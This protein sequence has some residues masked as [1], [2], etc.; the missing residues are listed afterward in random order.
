MIQ[1]DQPDNLVVALCQCGCGLPAPI[2]ARTYA[3]WGHVKG[4]PM[5]F[6]RGH[7]SRMG[8]SAKERFWANVVHEGDCWVWR[9]GRD[10]DGYG[11]LKVSG[12][13]VRAH[14]FAYEMYR[15]AAPGPMFV[16]HTC[17]NPPCV[18]PSH[19]FLGTAIDNARDA[20][21]KGRMARLIG[22]ANPRS[23]PRSVVVAVAA[24]PGSQREVA[25]RLGVAQA[26]VSRIRAGK[27]S[28]TRSAACL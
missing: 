10:A 2:A 12:K 20:A 5:R 15:G 16:C 11:Y 27:H 13:Q 25:R 22:E 1:R 14:R 6:A 24:A 18:N 4:E 7:A 21:G 28:F 19:L 23:L 26:T 9:G 8:P 17:D 3:K